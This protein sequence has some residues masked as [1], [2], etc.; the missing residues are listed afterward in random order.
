MLVLPMAANAAAFRMNKMRVVSNPGAKKCNIHSEAER[1]DQP[2]CFGRGKNCKDQ[3]CSA[4]GKSHDIQIP[5]QYEVRRFY[6]QNH[7]VAPVQHLN[8]RPYDDELSVFLHNLLENCLLGAYRI[9][10]V[11]QSLFD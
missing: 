9:R 2:W 1:S 6:G 11:Q 7:A 4:Y 10:I 5:T 8:R 3:C